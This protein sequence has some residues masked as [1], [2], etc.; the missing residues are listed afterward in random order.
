[1][2]HLKHSGCHLFYQME[3]R[4]KATLFIH[5][6]QKDWKEGKEVYDL[7]LSAVCN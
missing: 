7:L 5:Q 1:M 4:D 2:K 6:D 3:T